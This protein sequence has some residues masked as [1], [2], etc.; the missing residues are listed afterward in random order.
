MHVLLYRLR[1]AGPER[2]RG[3]WLPYTSDYGVL[4]IFPDEDILRMAETIRTSAGWEWK[5]G[6]IH[7]GYRQMAI[8]LELNSG[9]IVGDT[10]DFLCYS[11]AEILECL[12]RRSRIPVRHE[13]SPFV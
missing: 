4:Y 7:E 3:I 6:T 13:E 11:A 5:I 12:A 1:D 8:C 2:F 10:R 9:K